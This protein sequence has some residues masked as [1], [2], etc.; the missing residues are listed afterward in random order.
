MTVS[1]EVD[2]NDYTGN[3]VTTAFPYTFRIYKNSDLAVTVVDLNNNI[4]PLTLDTHYTVTGAKTYQGGNVVLTNPLASGWKIS[5]V[6]DLPVVQ[7]TD[8]R[9]QGKFFAEVHEDSFDYLTMLIQQCFAWQRL[10]LLKPT[11]TANFYD[12]KNQFIKNLLTPVDRNDASNKGYIDDLYAYLMQTVN[13]IIDT[14]KNG[15][16]GY[17]Q[18]RSFELGNTLNYPNDILLQESSGEWFRWDGPLPKVVPAG[19]TPGSTGGEGPGKWRSVG[20]AALRADLAKNTG[21]GLSGYN[22]TLTYP[23]GSVGAALNS[24]Y[25]RL[26]TVSIAD[27]PSLK[28]AIAAL[29]SGGTVYVPVGRWESGSWNTTDNNM[30][31]DNI[32]IIGERAPVWNSTLTRL[33]GGSVICNRFIAWANNLTIENIGFDAGRDYLTDKY[34][35]ANTATNSHPDG[36][37]WD[38]FVFGASGPSLT[39]KNGL[40][41]RNV[42]GLMYNSQALGHAVLTEGYSHGRLDNVTG[43]GGSHGVIIK[44]SDVVATGLYAYCQSANGLIIKADQFSGC[45]NVFVHDF[46]YGYQPRNTSPWFTPAYAL[47][48]VDIDPNAQTFNGA[49]YIGAVTTAGA[50]WGVHC[51]G[52]VPLADVHIGSIVSDGLAANSAVVG[53][54]AFIIDGSTTASRIRV[55]HVRVSN[56]KQGIYSATPSINPAAQLSIGRCEGV[57]ITNALITALDNTRIYID[58]VEGTTIGSLYFMTATARIYVGSERYNILTSTKFQMT[59]GGVGPAL[60]S[61][62][63]QAAD[64]EVFEVSLKNYRACVKGFLQASGG[65]GAPMVSLPASLRP[66][67]SPRFPSV[68][69]IS[70]ATSVSHVS[71][72][73]SV[74]TQDGTLPAG[75]QFV[76]LSGLEWDY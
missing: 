72:V 14:I 33:T 30:S 29:P 54:Y 27:Y 2:H 45:G 50:V 66:A 39:Q 76:S 49:I 58:Q 59:G 12:A 65:A 5:I 20:D 46:T 11:S 7:E 41:L 57:N 37:T 1:T 10:A 32:R 48:G 40:F 28:A 19:S 36:G 64:N 55:D 23:A 13:T 34:P 75:T 22:K 8:L 61:G 53:E 6:R 31:T 56:C 24:V 26:P 67:T 74:R 63:V 18:K 9:N 43:I 70:G 42:T 16:Y 21:A 15:L 17:N 35:G 71:V 38:A 69:I 60:I 3:G 47:H 73:D 62:W 4:I 68:Y 25:A 52:L 44:G 51:G